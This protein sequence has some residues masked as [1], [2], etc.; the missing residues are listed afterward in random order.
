M[1][2]KTAPTF[3]QRTKSWLGMGGAE[4]SWRGP[5]YGTGE[6][7]NSFMLGGWEDGFQR[8]LDVNGFNAR[9]V[10]PVYGIVML[11][12]RGGSQ[13]EP[14]HLVLNNS[15][16]FEKSMTSP[17][18]R[19]FRK[20]NPY[21]TWTQIIY[22]T[23]SE[24]LFEGES[25]WVAAR[26]DR[27]AV[28][29]VHRVPSRSWTVH[30]DD[31]SGEIFYG[32]SNSSDLLPGNYEALVPARDAVHF[33]QHCPRHPL[34]G[35]SPIKAAAMAI[36]INVALNRS[37]MTFFNNMSRPSGVITTDQTL[38]KEQI[39]RLK[40]AWENA[41]A[42][43]S[44]G[45]VPVLLNGLKFQPMGVA[46]DDAA[47]IEQ[48]KLSVADIARVF[49]VPMALI[50]DGAGAQ[51]ATESMISHW[52][53]VGLG[54]MLETIERSLERLFNL[55]ATEKIH[56][57]PTPLLRIDFA[58]R[59]DGLVKAVQGGLL[60]PDEARQREGF[61]TTAGGDQTFMQQQM[62]PVDLLLEMHSNSLTQPTEP[63][64]PPEPQDEGDPEISKALVVSMLN[65][66]R[67]AAANER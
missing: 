28:Q 46:Q 8:N 45:R 65:T 47:L 64:P 59:I 38:N 58:S 11:Y 9:H 19:I 57:D 55:P 54:S 63:A 23:I 15:G 44:Q 56:L 17:A 33:R 3:W 18:S 24:I 30:V 37:Q 12:A 4:G 20:P 6:F 41:S 51:G 42:A 52:L 29:A 13:A 5:F 62:V 49:G 1:E 14:Q 10:A 2:Q 39:T 66:K 21:E 25:L 40:E 26:D 32:I 22:N 67:K 27:F 53:S 35:E 60:S 50:S 61:G 31:E 16:S 36:G 48:Q 34:M 7:G 43:I